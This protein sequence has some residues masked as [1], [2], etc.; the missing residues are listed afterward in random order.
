MSDIEKILRL[1]ELADRLDI[2]LH[3]ISTNLYDAPSALT[4]V[5]N[6]FGIDVISTV[7]PHTIYRTFINEL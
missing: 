6:M 3:V 5:E 1:C 2:R 7:I 4:Q